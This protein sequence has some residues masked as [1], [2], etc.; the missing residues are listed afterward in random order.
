[1]NTITVILFFNPTSEKWSW[2][3]HK[4]SL[5]KFKH[6]STCSGSTCDTFGCHEQTQATWLLHSWLVLHHKYLA[7]T[8]T[9]MFLAVLEH[10]SLTCSENSQYCNS[11]TLIF[12][13]GLPIAVLHYH[14]KCDG[15]VCSIEAA[16]RTGKPW[17]FEFAALHN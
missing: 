1:M 13:K 8:E 15:H 7:N 14:R 17:K 11:S 9:G 16:D 4:N 5:T 12:W 6:A 3:Q 10:K 2:K